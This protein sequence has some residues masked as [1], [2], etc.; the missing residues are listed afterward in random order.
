VATKGTLTRPRTEAR[1]RRAL[2]VMEVMVPQRH[3]LGEEAEAD[4]GE[5][6]VYI[7]VILTGV[8]LFVM[9]LSTSGQVSAG[10]SQ[11]SAGGVPRRPRPGVRGFWRVPGTVRYDN[12]KAAVV[13]VTK[14]PRPHRVG[15]VRGVALPLRLRVV[16]LPVRAPVRTVLD[17]AGTRRGRGRPTYQGIQATLSTP[18]AR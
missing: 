3:P 6:S 15:A 10:L 1:R 2:P 18:I 9:R 4:F 17:V 11:R 8:H 7:D 5:I 12:L 14:G 16:L 13:R